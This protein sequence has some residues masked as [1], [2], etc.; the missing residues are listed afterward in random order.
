[1]LLDEFLKRNITLA[2]VR[3]EVAA[4]SG[5]AASAF[6]I[7]RP[8]SAF[9]ASGTRPERAPVVGLKT[10]PKRPP[11]FASAPRT[12]LPPMKWVNSRAC[13]RVA[14]RVFIKTSTVD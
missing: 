9:E 10:S 1:M 8:V 14:S 13:T 4:H 6:A 12:C 3:G 2:R 7:A 5:N 11:L